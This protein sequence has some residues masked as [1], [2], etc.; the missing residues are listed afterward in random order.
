MVGGGQQSGIYGREVEEIESLQTIPLAAV[1]LVNVPFPSTSLPQ[2]HDLWVGW[3]S[4][5][6]IL[7]VLTKHVGPSNFHT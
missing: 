3:G 7:D 4:N 2:G 5:I 1:K 6:I